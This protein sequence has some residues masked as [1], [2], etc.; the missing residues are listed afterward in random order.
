M[1]L[2]LRGR[3]SPAGALLEPGLLFPLHKGRRA[4]GPCLCPRHCPP[5]RDALVTDASDGWSRVQST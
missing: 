5:G 3:G 1:W 4:W 2:C